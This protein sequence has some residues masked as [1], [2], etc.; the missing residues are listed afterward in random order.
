MRNLWYVKQPAHQEKIYLTLHQII[1]VHIVE[2]CMDEKNLTFYCILAGDKT[3]LC[4]QKL[5]VMLVLHNKWI[6]F[7]TEH[8]VMGAI[9]NKH[10]I[11][12]VY[13]NYN[14]N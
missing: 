14:S 8:P 7:V 3:N 2:E 12:N 9:C 5:R 1:R 4:S 13:V 10:V 6:H 11:K